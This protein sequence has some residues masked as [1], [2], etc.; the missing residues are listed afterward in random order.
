MVSLIVLLTACQGES[1]PDK[2][3]PFKGMIRM[4]SDTLYFV[5]CDFR[6]LQWVAGGTAYDDL[7]DNY[8][9]ASK[10]PSDFLYVYLQ[11]IMA[12]IPID[13]GNRVARGLQV[14]QIDS[15][16][17]GY[18]CLQVNAYAAGGKYRYKNTE[19]LSNEIELVLGFNGR[20]Q[21]NTL[22]GF[23]KFREPGQWYAIDSTQVA[24][25]LN[26][27]DTLVGKVDWQRNLTLQDGRFADPIK[28]LRQ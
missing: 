25:I 6:E 18:S 1:V 7:M 27:Q 24:M 5:D 3:Y 22:D 13:Q 16:V 15:I 10:D 11:G 21:M 9:D 8:Q 4:Q 17:E 26:E 23:R 19:A 20:A 12:N 28:L 2:L 14:Y